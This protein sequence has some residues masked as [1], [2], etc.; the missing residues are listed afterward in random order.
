MRRIPAVLC[1][2]MI[3]VALLC[4]SGPRAEGRLAIVPD[5]TITINHQFQVRIVVND[6]IESLMGYDVTVSF[7]DSSLE[8]V[9]VGE[10]ALPANSGF[11]TFFRWMNPGC[12]CDSVFVIG[13]ILGETVDG[14]GAL[15]T[16]TFRAIRTGTTTIGVR[17]SDLRSGTNESLPHVVE[18]AIVCI[19][20]PPSL[21]V[22]PVET[23]TAVFHEFQ[24]E[25]AANEAIDGLMGYD[26]TVDF[27]DSYL[28]VLAVEEGALPADSGLP[29]FFRWMNPGCGCD[30][31]FVNG[32]IL[33]DTV[34]GPG[35]L[36]TITFRAIQPGTTAIGVRRS[37]LR[38]GANERL[39][40]VVEDA[41]VFIEP[42]PSLLVLPAETNTFVFQEF[43]IE[44]AAN[45]DVVGL[46]G[47]DVTISFDDSYLEVLA[48][49]EG[50]LPA[51][52][53]LPTF[54]RWMNPGC[55]CDSVF[56][57]GAI[58]GNTVDGPGAL[59]TITFR[60]IRA[61]TTTIG[62]RRSDLRNGANE[63]V[64]HFRYDAQVLIEYPATGAD[65]PTP[66]SGALVNYPNP[67]NPSTMIVLLMPRTAPGSNVELAVYSA[68]GRRIRSLLS[69]PLEGDR[70]VF[71]WDGKDDAGRTVATGFYIAVARAGGVVL[72]RKM[73]LIR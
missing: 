34:D 35:A 45:D 12:G 44:I 50:A 5:T 59:F 54:F 72:Q 61:G 21:L 2:V 1:L 57:N 6:E 7:D 68:S 40:H 29:T 66:P 56:V 32:A 64:Q 69:G 60:A 49:E 47:Y 62:I 19:E 41:I 30:S 8:I 17:R 25:I 14:P 70:A 31:V 58:L 16:I 13:S 42:P 20:P 11:G 52:S 43:Q 27:D 67:F 51:D 38:G 23:N 36:F 9:A 37:D 24:I 33:G 18:D 4:P 53:G 73:V 46:M 63:R 48:V 55:G 26:V 65:F 22:L 39:A 71:V 15:F 10:G 28:E 3:T